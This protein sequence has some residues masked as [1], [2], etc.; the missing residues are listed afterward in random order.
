MNKFDLEFIAVFNRV[1]KKRGWNRVEMKQKSIIIRKG[2]CSSFKE[3]SIFKFGVKD[4]E[5]NS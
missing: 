3:Q 4:I 5:Q 1:M 2:F